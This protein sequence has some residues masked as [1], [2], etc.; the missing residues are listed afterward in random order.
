[1]RFCRSMERTW[2]WIDAE[3]QI[4]GIS[5]VG[6]DENVKPSSRQG[7]KVY[8]WTRLSGKVKTRLE[9]RV[10]HV[11]T[12]ISTYNDPQGCM[13]AST[14]KQLRLTIRRGSPGIGR[15]RLQRWIHNAANTDTNHGAA[16][17]VCTNEPPFLARMGQ[18]LTP[19][20]EPRRHLVT[21][22]YT[23]CRSAGSRYG[24]QSDCQMALSPMPPS[25]SWRTGLELQ[26]VRY[27][28]AFP[29]M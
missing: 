10:I 11:E 13:A 14:K 20:R 2:G 15:G 18:R 3:D 16:L 6:C 23:L 9:E 22:Q 19:A 8:T 7:W 24:A 4:N 5:C 28:T 17:G 21:S 25:R 12:S 1:M 26:L 29:L 27:S